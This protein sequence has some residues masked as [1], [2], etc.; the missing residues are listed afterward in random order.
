M[1]EQLE[2]KFRLHNGESLNRLVPRVFNLEDP[3]GMKRLL[4][5]NQKELP[6]P[7][8]TKTISYDPYL[9]TGIGV[10]K[11]DTGKI[12]SLGAYAFAINKLDS[13]ANLKSKNLNAMT[14]N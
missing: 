13:D 14:V 5:G 8:T 10:T 1:F 7:G 2:S 9:R 6:I 12:I 4:D 11:N 3:I